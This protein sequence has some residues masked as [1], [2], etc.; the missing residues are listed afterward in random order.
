[1]GNKSEKEIKV[2]GYM[3][4]VYS[5]IGKELIKDDLTI[6]LSNFTHIIS[7]ENR[8]ICTGVEFFKTEYTV[9][10]WLFWTKKRT[11]KKYEKT[12]VNADTVEFNGETYI[13]KLY[14]D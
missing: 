14:E 4:E 11:E 3:K 2:I 8:L 9:R 7:R 6:T 1:M 10:H 13:T 12:Y 5:F